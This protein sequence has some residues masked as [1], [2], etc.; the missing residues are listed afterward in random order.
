MQKSKFSTLVND[1]KTK[2]N[3]NAICF[4]LVF[5]KNST[6]FENNN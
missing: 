5:G 6:K 3:L 4:D 1:L 2:N